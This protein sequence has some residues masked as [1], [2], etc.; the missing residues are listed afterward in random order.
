VK[1]KLGYPITVP[2]RTQVQTPLISVIV[3]CY[4]Y[5][6]FLDD[7][8]RS[9]SR[10]TIAHLIEVIVIDPDSIRHKAKA[11]EAIA[12]YKDSINVRS[13][14]RE[15]RHLLGCNRN[16]GANLANAPF[17]AF[18]DADDQVH[19]SFYELALFKILFRKAD[20]VGAGHLRQVDKTTSFSRARGMHKRPDSKLVQIDNV[21][22]SQ[23][24]ID[25]KI[26]LT[27][28]GF[29]DTG[30][31]E[32]L[33]Y[34]D[35]RFFHRAI[36]AG[37]KGYNLP[38]DLILYRIH[39]ASQ[40][41]AGGIPSINLQRKFIQNAN[42]DVVTGN[43]LRSRQAAVPKLR[44]KM[45]RNLFIQGVFA[46]SSID[47]NPIVGTLNSRDPNRWAVRFGISGAPII[48]ALGVRDGILYLALR[49]AYHSMTT[50]NS[51]FRIGR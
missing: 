8:L 20:I 17:L 11:R 15:S 26:M 4:N 37:A 24:L 22:G 2:P 48:W 51:L 1:V 12:K 39:A 40:S 36:L 25:K 28:G 29:C 49:L 18:L 21:F 7:C 14:K 45:L 10:Q 5:G 43:L 13:V 47:I 32:K 33:I 30:L 31:G 44:K 23:A 41:N 42:A 27:I 34:E 46:K 38:A 3:I 9:L 35:W 50:A 6:N 19:C 16:Y